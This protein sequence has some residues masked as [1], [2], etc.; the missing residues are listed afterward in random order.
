MTSYREAARRTKPNA[1]ER[2][3]FSGS[4]EATIMEPDSRTGSDRPEIAQTD[5]D[6]YRTAFKYNSM[7]DPMPI[8]RI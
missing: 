5:P 1:G 4:I 2:W 8:R 6:D 7:Q 3:V